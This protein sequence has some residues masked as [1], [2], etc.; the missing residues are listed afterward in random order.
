MELKSEVVRPEAAIENWSEMEMTY[1]LDP[2]P[3]A[4]AMVIKDK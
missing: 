4:Y 3:V 1:R 2:A